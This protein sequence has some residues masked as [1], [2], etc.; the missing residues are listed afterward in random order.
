MPFTTAHEADGNNV[1]PDSVRGEMWMLK[2]ELDTESLGFT[3][4]AL[5]PDEETMSHSHLDE[6]VEEIYYVVSGGVDVEFEDRRVSL[7]QHEMIHI[8]PDEERQI[9]NRE[10]FSK[11]VLVSAPT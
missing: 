2:D 8:S 4:L 7:D 11:L 6:E 9:R 5:E 1:L 3:V 10:E